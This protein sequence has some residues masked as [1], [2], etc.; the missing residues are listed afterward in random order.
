M[1]KMT[2]EWWRDLAACPGCGN[3][4]LSWHKHKG[5]SGECAKCGKNFKLKNNI[6]CWDRTGPAEKKASLPVFM[7]RLRSFLHPISS[8]ILPFRYLACARLESFYHRTL[9]DSALAKRWADHYLKALNLPNEAAVLDFGCGRGRNIG[10][11]NQLG[12]GVFGQD[13]TPHPWW[14]RF[15]DCGFQ[16]TEDSSNLPWRDAAFDLVVEVEVIHYI[17][18]TQLLKHAQEIKRI[19]KPGGYW[20]MLEGNSKSLGAREMRRQIGRLHEIGKIKELAAGN[21]FIEISQSF[22]G[23]SSPHFPIIVDFIRKLCVPR[24]FDISDYD[25]WSAKK[26]KPQRRSLW[27]LRLKKPNK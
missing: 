11:L 21:S 3:G 26:I 10:I 7:R 16:A 1:T 8:P 13:L 22:E 20:I 23:F 25:S 14:Q 5:E 9:T 2:S 15:P 12:Y 4:A 24:K 17:P 6:L 18:E 19:L 27:L